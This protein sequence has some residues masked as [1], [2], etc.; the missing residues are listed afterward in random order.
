M[1]FQ[2]GAGASPPNLAAVRGAAAR[3]LRSVLGR[4][5]VVG[6]LS[7]LGVLGYA[8]AASAAG[9]LSVNPWVSGV[10]NSADIEYGAAVAD[11]PAAPDPAEGGADAVV[12]ELRLVRID[13]ASSC[14]ALADRLDRATYYGELVA[15][16]QTA[17][18]GNSLYQR[19]GDTRDGIAELSAMATTQLELASCN[20]DFTPEDEIEDHVCGKVWLA[21]PAGVRIDLAGTGVGG[22][23]AVGVSNP[24]DVATPVSDSVDASGIALKEG[25]WYLVG[26]LVAA[27]VGYVFYRQVMPRA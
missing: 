13:A 20:A 8:S 14:E 12:V 26:A 21:D 23:L 24:L 11:C 9:D 5:V 1:G 6:A 3:L 4:V 25:V 16:E 10:D 7:L 27:F 19:L 15:W 22:S 17:G 2:H 18:A